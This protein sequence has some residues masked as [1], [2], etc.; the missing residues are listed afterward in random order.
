MSQVSDLA[1]WVV[2]HVDKSF[3]KLGH[4]ARLEMPTA[5]EAAYRRAYPPPELTIE[6]RLRRLRRALGD[7]AAEYIDELQARIDEL[8]NPAP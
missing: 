7:E 1:D 8:E 4:Q 3:F 2:A 5:L 6:E